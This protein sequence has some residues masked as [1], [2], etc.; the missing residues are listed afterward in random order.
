[1]KRTAPIVSRMN[2]IVNEGQGRRLATVSV[3][4]SAECGN[5]D[6]LLRSYARSVA[7]ENHVRR[8]TRQGS[9][10]TFPGTTPGLVWHQATY[11]MH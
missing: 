8:I 7:S 1:M 5:P 9:V 2:T 3:L 4:V 6:R 10:Q 11:W